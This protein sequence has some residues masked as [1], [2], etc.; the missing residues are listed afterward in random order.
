MG[1]HSEYADGA[2]VGV[3]D[4]SHLPQARAS[5]GHFEATANEGVPPGSAGNSVSSPTRREE[6]Q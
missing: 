2:I 5:E 4:I 1:T 3:E 6:Q